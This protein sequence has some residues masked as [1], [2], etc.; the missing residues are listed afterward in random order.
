MRKRLRIPR[1]IRAAAGPHDLCPGGSDG[2]ESPAEVQ[3]DS[4]SSSDIVSSP[5]YD[6]DDRSSTT[7]RFDSGTDIVVH[8]TAPVRSFLF[9]LPLSPALIDPK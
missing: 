3:C 1:V 4:G 6:G 2:E 5:F 9:L 8:N 7:S